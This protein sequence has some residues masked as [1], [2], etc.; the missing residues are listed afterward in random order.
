M[1]VLLVGAYAALSGQDYNGDMISLGG[2]NAWACSPSNWLFG[3]VAGGDAHKGS[4]GTDQLPF[5]GMAAFTVTPSNDMINDKWKAVYEGITRCNNVLKVLPHVTD[6]TPDELTNTKAQARFL[7]GHYYF[8]LKKLFN[9]V[10]WIDE[11]TTRFQAAKQ[12]RYLAKN[13]S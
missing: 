10:P 3:S 2:G 5:M 8:E 12:C 7:R 9:M 4:D 13:R 11:N 1:N 6:M